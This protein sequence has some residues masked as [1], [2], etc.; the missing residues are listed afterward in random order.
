MDELLEAI[1]EVQKGDMMVYPRLLAR[2]RAEEEAKARAAAEE[3]LMTMWYVVEREKKIY[4]LH[5]ADTG[6]TTIPAEKPKEDD[7][8]TAWDWMGLVGT[9]GLMG[10]IILKMIAN[11]V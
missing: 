8:L 11:M 2:Q 1:R 9:I 6:K 7:R 4:K 3:D 5:D 10:F